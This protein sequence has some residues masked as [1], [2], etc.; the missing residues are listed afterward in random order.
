LIAARTY[1]EIFAKCEQCA[2]GHCVR[3]E[4]IAIVVGAFRLA[5]ALEIG[6]RQAQQQHKAKPQQAIQIHR[7]AA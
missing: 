7:N 6:F 4:S 1:F 3:I 5:L 2:R